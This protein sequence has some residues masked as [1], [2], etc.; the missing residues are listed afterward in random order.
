MLA[1]SEAMAAAESIA[2]LWVGGLKK[3][4][5]KCALHGSSNCLELEDRRG[6]SIS[7]ALG[8]FGGRR[9]QSAWLYV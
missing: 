7:V 8:G 5:S 3:R 9:G 6:I 1:A 4:A 2:W